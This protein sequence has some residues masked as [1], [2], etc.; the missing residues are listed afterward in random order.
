[1]FFSLSDS[2]AW[3]LL[4]A[5][6]PAC[7]MLL[8]AAACLRADAP[9]AWR[10]ARLATSAALGLALLV[11]LAL[12]AFGPSGNAFV[13][14]D[15][16]TGTVGLLVA[17]VG[18]IIVRYSQRYL[19]GN[20]GSAGYVRA[21]LLTLA[22]V[23][24]VVV[25]NHLLVLALAWTVSSLGLHRLLKFFPARRAAVIAAHKKHVVATVANA[26]MVLAAVL[27]YGAFDSWQIDQLTALAVAAPELPVLAQTAVV[28]IVLAA[29]LKCA[30]LPVH[31]WLIQVMEAPTPVS[32]LLHAGVVNLGGLVLIRLAPLVAEVQWA[33][34]LLVVIGGLS[35]A[36]AALVMTTRI[37]V[38]VM[39]AWST[40]AQMGFMLMQCGLGLWEM[41]LLHLVGHSLYKAH[42]FLSAGGVVRQ[43]LVRQLAPVPAVPGAGALALALL[44]AL[45]ST[46]LV[47]LAS[48]QLAPLSAPLAVMAGVL[49]LAL[50]PLLQPA[51]T[52]P[53]GVRTWLRAGLA[54]A[55]LAGV[56]FT[57]HLLLQGWVAPEAVPPQLPLW[58]FVAAVF[59]LLFLVQLA[60]QARPA[61]IWARRLYP[62]IYGGL[63]LDEWFSRHA[64]RLWPAP[65]MHTASTAAAS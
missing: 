36:I 34:A 63:F 9:R 42:A 10:Q 14:A 35:A 50:V 39:L 28:L 6:T 55:A 56:Y 57:L 8:G 64:L 60:V 15:G 29:I 44:A 18:W 20:S 43:S 25:S 31:G 2:P 53:S 16:I 48:T 5:A 32:A 21:L 58:G 26:G 23:L 49:A 4:L 7:A 46:G 12:A 45:A 52:E 54:A 47:L 11:L 33:M 27:L 51:A 41:A 3:H 1:M 13:R 65:A 22:C 59:T 38:K 19:D 40:C 24:L 62:W 37:S 61:V 30:Q 17:F